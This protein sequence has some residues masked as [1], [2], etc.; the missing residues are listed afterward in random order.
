MAVD[1][2]NKLAA[3]WGDKV[4]GCKRYSY[5]RLVSRLT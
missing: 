4:P 1:Y 3:V 5:G 2:T